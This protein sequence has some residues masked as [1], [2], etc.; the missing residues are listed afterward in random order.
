VP[1]GVLVPPDDDYRLVCDDGRAAD[2]RVFFIDLPAGRAF[3]R[4]RS[5]QGD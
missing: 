4:L 5:R 1:R 3:F 2:L